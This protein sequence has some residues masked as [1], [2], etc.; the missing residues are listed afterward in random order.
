MSTPFNKL[1]N[2]PLQ[3]ELLKEYLDKRCLEPDDFPE[4]LV[5]SLSK[6][7]L[8]QRGY[9]ARLAAGRPYI[10]LQYLDPKGNPY[11]EYED[12]SKSN[13][14]AVARFLGDPTLWQG[15]EPPPKVI[16]PNGRQNQLHF[17]PVRPIEGQ[18][19]DWY[20]LPDGQIVVHVE[21]MIKARAV[22]K[23]TGFPTVGYNGVASYSSSKRGIELLHKQYDVDF[24]RFTNVILFDSNIH[25]PAVASAREG[26]AFK[27]R[28]ILG[29]QDIRLADLP[30]GPNG[31]DWGPDDFL[32]HYGNEPLIELIRSS[33]TWSGQEH[34]DLI[35]QIQERAVYCTRGGTFIDRRDKSVRQ[36]VKAS[37][38]YAPINKKVLKGKN[39]ATVYGFPLWKEF[40]DRNEVVNPAYEYLGEEFIERDD[41]RYYNLYQRSGPWPDLR[42]PK[43]TIIT[44][45]LKNMMSVEDLRLLR[46]YMKFLKYTGRKPTSFPV[47]FS[48]KRG[49]GKGWFSKLAYRFIGASNSTS[50]DARAFVSNFNVQLANK[51]LVVI[52]EFKVSN[53]EKPSAMN[54]IKRF[55][56]DELITIEPKGVDSYSLENRAGMIITCNNLE[57]V[58]T[59]GLED[60]RMWYIDCSNKE[61]VENWS[62]LH[63]ALDDPEM[64]EEFCH[65]VA[66]ADDI[67]FATWRPPLD[68]TKRRAIVAASSSLE[69][70]CD[71]ILSDLRET[72][73]I[74]LQYDAVKNFMKD[75][76]PRVM[77]T[78]GKAVTSAMKAAGWKSTEKKYGRNG[79][80]K[81][82][83]IINEEAFAQ[84]AGNGT[85]V[86]S[87]C[88]RVLKLSQGHSK[89]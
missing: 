42:E 89:Y 74:C 68:E 75:E 50:A 64:I 18:T 35:S 15:K 29:C 56:G 49:V 26:L 51:R 14:Y 12:E 45:Q 24:T 72:D 5:P 88:D 52:N 80:Q 62:P 67:D 79:A 31:E 85:A 58:P 70:A 83:W 37:T 77:E 8:V 59:D 7:L 21:S 33:T 55:F 66:G 34:D 41:G 57:D 71:T 61:E 39:V 19:R 47:L 48:D 44:D 65:W 25:K 43:E 20:N 87:E 1:F 86:T 9:D 13:P 81:I 69:A 2:N 30:K 17:E 53:A 32:A 22:H 54:S 76:Y 78:A 23:W 82:V 28:H 27:L 73:I 36:E 3:I 46:A 4:G 40:K 84:I 11:Y 6:D 60:R 16:S 38:F 63:A 10:F